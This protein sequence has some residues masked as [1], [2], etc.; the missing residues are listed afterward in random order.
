V[1]RKRVAI[2]FPMVL[3]PILGLAA[4]MPASE[5]PKGS[6]VLLR[7]VN[8]I[9]TR[10]AQ[11]GDYVYMTTASP[12][13][14][15]GRL[16]VPVNSHVQGLVVHSLRGGQVKGKAQLAIRLETLTL[17]QGKVFRFS[18]V[19]D[20]VDSNRSGQQVD[21]DENLIRQ[22]SDVGRDAARIAILAGTGA[23]I[24]GIV[25]ESW[26]GAGIGSAVGA[27]VGLATVLLTRGRDIELN[28][29]S[30]LDVVL[31]QPVTLEAGA[32]STMGR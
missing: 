19:L 20:S 1:F 17:P 7:M 9:T 12:I 13:S 2:R 30:S 23:S 24:G 15:E 26:K 4:A 29:G 21:K 16:V 11:P 32:P 8:S 5:I 31:D 10:T 18:P 3:A 6:H 27:G 14:V 28:R 22:G 25:D